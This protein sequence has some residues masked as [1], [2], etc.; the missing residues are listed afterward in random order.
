MPI[1]IRRKDLKTLV[2]RGRA[3]LIDVLPAPEYK[4]QHIPRAIN[5]PL[6]KLNAET[7]RSLAKEDAVIVYS[8]SCQC[9]RSARAAWRL[10]ILGFHEVYR[11]TPGKADWLAAGWPTDG[12]EATAAGLSEFMRKNVP[13]CSLR[14]RLGEVK[15]RRQANDDICVVVNDRNIVLGVIQE[16]AWDANPAARVVDVMDSG[17]PTVRPNLAPKEAR[18]ILRDYDASSV[19]VTTCDGELLGTVRI[20]KSKPKAD[21]AA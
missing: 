13:T 12:I 10:E 21:E 1:E 16:E 11:Y 20:A 14:E 9:D 19:I 8:A 6:E 3:Q 15:S 17:P 5:I 18:E 2:D 7:T 4:K